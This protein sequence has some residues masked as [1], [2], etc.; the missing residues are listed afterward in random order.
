MLFC[1][2]Y[3][4]RTATAARTQMY[5]LTYLLF[6]SPAGGGSLIWPSYSIGWRR[7]RSVDDDAVL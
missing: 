3:E 2:A 6:G 5:L 1:R 7:G 4:T